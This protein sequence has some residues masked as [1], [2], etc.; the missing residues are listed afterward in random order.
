VIGQISKCSTSP[1]R[2]SGTK[3]IGSCRGV[4]LS[5][6]LPRQP[7]KV[8]NIEPS[9]CDRESIATVGRNDLTPRLER[10]TDAGEVALQRC[11]SCRRRLVTP[12]RVTQTVDRNDL[13]AMR[14]QN[15]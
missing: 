13:T 7:I 14:C 15:A 8:I 9:V 11:D 10:T 6:R 4:R 12:K 1:P 3:Q 5:R 2:Q